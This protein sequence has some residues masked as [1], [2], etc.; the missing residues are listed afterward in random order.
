VKANEYRIKFPAPLYTFPYT[1]D[2][3]GI[4]MGVDKSLFLQIKQQST[5]LKKC[6]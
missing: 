1:P 5:G 4:G 3:Q 2:F 6:I